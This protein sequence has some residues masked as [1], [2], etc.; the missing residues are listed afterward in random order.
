MSAPSD[1]RGN[2]LWVQLILL[3]GFLLVVAAGIFTV[4]IPDLTDEPDPDVS[5]AVDAGVP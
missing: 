1:D 2:P 5:G 3:V 4:L